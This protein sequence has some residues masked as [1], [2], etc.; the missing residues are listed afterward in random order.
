MSAV[1][2][3]G[4]TGSYDHNT[5]TGQNFHITLTA[6]TS[7]A[8]RELEANHQGLSRDQ[9]YARA[10]SAIQDLLRN[11]STRLNYNGQE[12]YYFEDQDDYDDP[13]DPGE[14]GSVSYGVPRDYLDNLQISMDYLGV[15]SNAPASVLDRLLQ[16]AI[17]GPDSMYRNHDIFAE[18]W[19]EAP[20]GENCMV[21]QLFLAVTERVHTGSRK[22]DNTGAFCDANADTRERTPKY[23]LEE[24]HTLT[25]D[26]ELLVHPETP[27]FKE[28]QAPT[29][30]E[31]QELVRR[32]RMERQPELEAQLDNIAKW[33]YDLLIK[34][35]K[36]DVQGIVRA[37]NNR[38]NDWFKVLQ[39]R[40]PQSKDRHNSVLA[41]LQSRP[42]MFCFF[43]VRPQPNISTSEARQ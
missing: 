19:D 41:L 3:N 13:N 34:K 28:G 16:K 30:S 12:E 37:I 27:I 43:V 7:A 5:R 22:R 42:M 38:C 32:R 15:T 39:R 4:T 6:D 31:L 14:G 8:I 40:W 24:W 17:R 33:L 21:T 18:A 23:T 36:K 2:A 35:G 10:S 26:T 29:E 20:E 1:R 25:H 11:E 9:M